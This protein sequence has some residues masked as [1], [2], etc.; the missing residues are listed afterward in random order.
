MSSGEPD[1][2]AIILLIFI[3]PKAQEVENSEKRRKITGSG[4]NR[5][6]KA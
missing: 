2:P 6:P 1:I 4:F 3:Y 5:N